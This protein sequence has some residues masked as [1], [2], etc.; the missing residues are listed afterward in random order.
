MSREL[1]SRELTAEQFVQFG[2]YIRSHSGIHLE[3]NKRDPLRVS[4]IARATR[5]GCVSLEEYFEVLRTNEDEFDE[6]LNLITINETSFF[7]FAAQF[8]A[9][10]KTVIPR[11]L[12]SKPDVSRS[13]KVWSAGCS[14][15]EEPYSIAMTLLDSEA[16]RLEYRPEV[17]G[18]DVST[19][20]LDRARTGVYTAKAL[21]GLPEHLV[22]KY[23][24]LDGA[25]FRV[26]KPVRDVV[27]FSYHN[28]VKEPYPVALTGNWDVIFCRNV[29]IYFHLSATRRV[30][31][32][33][34]ESL[35]PGGFLF[36]GH[37]ETLTSISDHFDPVEA[38]GVF[39]YRKPHVRRVHSLTAPLSTAER[40]R[41]STVPASE[42][43]TE[44][45][46]LRTERTSAA[47]RHHVAP[48]LVAERRA[49]SLAES[50]ESLQTLVDAAKQHLAEGSPSA[51]L[52]L[53][54]KAI[55]RD[56]R[57]V[58]A[59]LVMAYAHADSGDFTAAL[60][61]CRRTLAIN[62]LV[63]AAR[64]ILGIIYMRLE[65]PLRA[66][67]EFKRTLY[68]DADFVLARFHLANLYRSRGST[69]DACREYENTLRSLERSPHGDWE[70]FLDGFT[71][72]VLVR[73]S[74]R[75]VAE[76]HRVAAGG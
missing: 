67:A 20:A 2:G 31:G 68:I 1:H 61:E 35:N 13:F 52:R 49:A 69:A 70:A 26:S 22:Q 57:N 60:E 65:E 62:P 29:T 7:R 30:V 51:A 43:A 9:L 5:W 38:D 71:P 50:D 36:L 34:F 4:L 21:S 23:F 10:R 59:Y 44:S 45:V 37:S 54:Q 6:L 58:D 11:V 53:A 3:E 39:L 64:F 16:L 47:T 15:G 48:V 66:I 72:D 33:F 74:E 73:T 27:E 56:P 63:A 25:G 14:T 40:P 17:L 8:E 24:E 19:Q 32:N 76:C 12:E 75:A 55:E 28:L 42:R 18:T 41:R 46:L